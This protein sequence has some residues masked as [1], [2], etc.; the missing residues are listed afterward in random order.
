MAWSTGAAWGLTD[1]RSAAWSCEKYRADMMLTIDADDAWW[2]P[3]FTPE[4][5]GRTLLAWWTWLAASHSTRRWTRSSTSRWGSP[6]GTG[7]AVSAR[8]LTSRVY[9]AACGSFLVPRLA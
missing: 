8:T 9:G 6:A 3:T 4:A 5:L 1:T 2:P 7:S